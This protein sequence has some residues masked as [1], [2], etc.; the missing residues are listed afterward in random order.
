MKF[1]FAITTLSIALDTL[2]TNEPIKR[3]EGNIEQADQDLVSIGEHEAAI[4]VLKAK[5]VEAEGSASETGLV[6]DTAPA[7]TEETKQDGDEDKAPANEA[8]EKTE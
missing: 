8:P 5:E 6:G 4:E 2:R 3:G 7:D 1:A